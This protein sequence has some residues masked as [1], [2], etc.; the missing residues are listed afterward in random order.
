MSRIFKTEKRI[1]REAKYQ[2]MYAEYCELAANPE[3]DKMAII[4]HLTD[5]HGISQSC[6]YLYLKKRRGQ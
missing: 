2:A 6:I 3:N 4:G 1:R 5:K